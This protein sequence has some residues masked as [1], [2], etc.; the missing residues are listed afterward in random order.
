[1]VMSYLDM[2]SRLCTPIH[3]AVVLERL[4]EQ[5][6]WWAESFQS[7]SRGTPTA[8]RS[9]TVTLSEARPVQATPILN[10]MPRRLWGLPLG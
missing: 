8:M 2:S 6:D 9:L 7:S 5:R 1:M 10:G 3:S 4:F